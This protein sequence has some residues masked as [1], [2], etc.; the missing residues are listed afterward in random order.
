MGD[1]GEAASVS[2]PPLALLECA[3]E[4]L[5]QFMDNFRTAS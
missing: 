1:A 5:Q 2:L 4:A 3:S